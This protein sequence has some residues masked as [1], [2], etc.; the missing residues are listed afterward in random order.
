MS[1]V[2]SGDGRPEDDIEEGFAVMVI[3]S[4]LPKVMA[5]GPP[6][7]RLFCQAE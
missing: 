1:G 3:S 5:L 2:T 7:L 6:G 4:Y